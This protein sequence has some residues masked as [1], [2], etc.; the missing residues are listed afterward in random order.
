[1]KEQEIGREEWVRSTGTVDGG[2]KSNGNHHGQR[3]PVEGENNYREK[4][5]QI[6]E[7]KGTSHRGK[8]KKERKKAV[9]CG[10]K[11]EGGDRRL[12]LFRV[13][14]R[15]WGGEGVEGGGEIGDGGIH[16]WNIISSG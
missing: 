16:K 11:L 4:E 1:V 12:P 10:S 3:K 13:I 9:K 14:L 15:V 7:K 2:R 6:R 8:T 5:S